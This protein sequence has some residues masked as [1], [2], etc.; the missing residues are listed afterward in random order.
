MFKNAN[1][2]L[3][4]SLTSVLFIS[5]AS[6][7]DIFPEGNTEKNTIFHYLRTNWGAMK[8][9]GTWGQELSCRGNEHVVSGGFETRGISG[10]RTNGV[11][12]I[13][14]HPTSNRKWFIRLLNADDVTRDFR[15]Y[16]VCA[17]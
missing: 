1:V 13:A 9:G 11:R 3:S 8:A 14:S 15:G 4:M 10:N 17:E 6:A 5:V 16:I 7:A 2:V 12:M